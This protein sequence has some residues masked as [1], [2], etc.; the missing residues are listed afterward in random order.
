MKTNKQNLN[1]D[2]WEIKHGYIKKDYPWKTKVFHR[3][4]FLKIKVG[5]LSC[6]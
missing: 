4:W 2:F 5:L 3:P 1:K 6:I